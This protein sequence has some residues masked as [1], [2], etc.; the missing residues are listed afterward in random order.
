MGGKIS[1]SDRHKL[2]YRQKQIA[3]KMLK[4]MTG[5]GA[6][7]ISNI[8]E[9]RVKEIMESH[10]NYMKRNDGGIAKKTRVF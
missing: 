3:N 9:A 7:N 8:D 1:N 4:E 2:K 10:E 5:E 6:K